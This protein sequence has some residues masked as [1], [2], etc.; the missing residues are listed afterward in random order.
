MKAINEAIMVRAEQARINSVYLPMKAIV[1][2]SAYT[3][4]VV[5][6]LTNGSTLIGAQVALNSGA[7]SCSFTGMALLVCGGASRWTASG[8]ITFGDVFTTP[9]DTK[10]ATSQSDLMLH[11]TYHSWQWASLGPVNFGITYGVSSGLEWMTGTSWGCMN[12]LEYT[13]G[14]KGGGYVC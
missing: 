4:R 3:T 8:G 6:N 1:D 13:A 9:T 12:V 2:T 7:K 10:T 11:E 5:L 14:W